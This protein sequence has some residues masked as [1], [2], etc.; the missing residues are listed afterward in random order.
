MTSL[1]KHLTTGIA[2][3]V[4]TTMAWH[5]LSASPTHATD[6][7]SVDG[8]ICTIVGT[9]GDDELRGTT[10]ADVICGLA[11]NDR[12]THVDDNDLVFAGDGDDIVFANGRA[13]HIAAGAG[14]D[15]IY[16]E[17][18]ATHVD[19]G[20]GDDVVH[21]LAAHTDHATAGPGNDS[22]FIHDDANV[23]D[24]EKTAE[25]PRSDATDYDHDGLPVGV[26]HRI[27]SDPHNADTDNDG[28]DDNTEL[29]TGT[30]VTKADTNDNGTRDGDE[31]TDK[32]GVRNSEE[33]RDGTSTTTQ[34]SD[35]DGL[36]DGQE[37][38]HGTSPTADDTDND[39][40]T[41]GFEVKTKTD[42]RRTDTNNNGIDDGQESTSHPLPSEAKSATVTTNA[43]SVTAAS[44][45]VVPDSSAVAAK[46]PGFVAPGIAVVTTDTTAQPRSTDATPGPQVTVSLP[47]SDDASKELALA[48]YDSASGSYRLAENVTYS[49]DTETLNGTIPEAT[50]TAIVDK[51][52]FTT[53]AAHRAQTQTRRA[54]AGSVDVVLAVDRSGS[55]DDH[56]PKKRRFDSIRALARDITPST[57][58]GLIRF[59]STAQQLHKLTDPRDKLVNSIGYLTPGGK[60]KVDI[61]LGEA[62]TMLK[63][64]SR[65]DRKVVVLLSDGL[66]TEPYSSAA[67]EEAQRM[68]VTIHGLGAGT[69]GPKALLPVLASM[70]G[71]HYLEIGQG[72]ALAKI[73]NN[74]TTADPTVDSDGDGIKDVYELAGLQS[75]AGPVYATDPNNPDTDFD[76]IPDGD[77]ATLVDS[78]AG[79]PK[80]RVT[81]DPSSSDG[82]NDGLIDPDEK[83]EGT[84][85]LRSDT[86]NDGLT[87][88]FEVEA[89]FNPLD[90]NE[91]G[92]SFNDRAERFN[93]KKPWAYDLDGADVLAAFVLG[94]TAGSWAKDAILKLKVGKQVMLAST[95]LLVGH[96]L[97]GVLIV[98]DVRDLAKDL[99]DG[100]WISGVLSAFSIVPGAGDALKAVRTAA[101]TVSVVWE[102]T[103]ET[104]GRAAHSGP[105]VRSH[106]TG[107]DGLTLAARV[108]ST[109]ASMVPAGIPVETWTRRGAE[110]PGT[111]L[112]AAW[113]K[114]VD[115]AMQIRG[116]KL[117]NEGRRSP[118][119]SQ[120]LLDEFNPRHISVS[121]DGIPTPRDGLPDDDRKAA[122]A[123]INT[124]HNVS[125]SNLQKADLS[126]GITRR[127]AMS[128]QEKV[129]WKILA[130]I[131]Q[132]MDN[133][134]DVAQVRVNQR[135]LDGTDTA[136]QG[137][138]VRT[139]GRNRPDIQ[140]KINGCMHY[141]EIDTPPGARSLDHL[142]RILRNDK[143]QCVYVHLV[144]AG[145]PTP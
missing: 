139:A 138:N 34:D 24:C 11:G 89:M 61:G 143:T 126:K 111:P 33:A 15:D 125:N 2:T 6:Q 62:L 110:Q 4:A 53:A 68:G 94:M 16:L 142:Y 109:V 145:H 90:G 115:E 43:P 103:K 107:S 12:V 79:N 122:L 63:Q 140:A 82:D 40:L 23:A 47:V 70:T 128:Y 132:R 32:D 76:G 13:K 58:M 41:D 67:V 17:Q 37:K 49:Q 141:W 3:L 114:L 87:D 134:E 5:G 81:S 116:A 123:V 124:T 93:H 121:D 91:D 72:S 57:Q 100:D 85:P 135:Q 59:D 84:N 104:D 73:I 18:G 22:C 48:Y 108:P 136:E 95:P 1:G 118:S 20:D 88:G 113:N 7:V 38:L 117:W 19:A 71:G 83:L 42:P 21:I 101:I 27:G 64:S 97:S 144:T 29:S 78:N 96:V 65:A 106:L 10:G 86:D 77:E 31:D 60:T 14:N 129:K 74:Q 120:F 131:K 35:Q 28:L 112:S 44:L 36:T 75:T 99:W 55:M 52:F 80:F 137:K 102:L 98:G 92:D 51:K 46:L 119:Q 105:R 39:G 9:P 54:Q 50:S 25:D 45:E 30:S 66:N 69:P 133:G 26:E 8:H 130:E 127:L 56:D